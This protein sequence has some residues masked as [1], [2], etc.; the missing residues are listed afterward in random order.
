MAWDRTQPTD[1]TKLRNLGTVIR[2]NW[3]A[4]ELAESTFQPQALNFTDRTVAGV[5]VNPTA[6]ADTYISYCK[7]DSA[8]N[9]ELFGID[10]SSNIIQY[11]YGGRMGSPTT[12]LTVNTIHFGSATTNYGRNNIVQAFGQFNSAGT[13]IVAVNCTIVYVS[14]GIYQINFPSS[15]PTTNYVAVATPFNEGGVRLC[16]IDDKTTSNFRIYLYDGSN[17]AV[18][19]GAFF[20]VV[21]GFS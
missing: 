19:T 4:I 14:T 21:G 8:G 16:K 20:M 18:D 17:S 3:E 10:D 12:D 6:I 15:L 11:S 2:P 7:T 1:T 13:T 9:S 5:A